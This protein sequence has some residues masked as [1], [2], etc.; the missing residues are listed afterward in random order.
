VPKT[1]TEVLD[2]IDYKAVLGDQITAEAIAGLNAEEAMAIREMA[3]ANISIAEAPD[4]PVDLDGDGAD[5]PPP[6]VTAPTANDPPAPAEPPAP[7]APAE[8]PP[9]IDR[10][11]V[12][13]RIAELDGQ[14]DAL[15]D[16]YDNGE[17]SREELRTKQ[18][19][20][21]Q[22]RVAAQL[23]L[24]RADEAAQAYQQQTV[25][26]YW[27][28]VEQIK[29]ANPTFWAPVHVTGFNERVLAIQRSPEAK[30][31]TVD[32]VFTAAMNTYR[33]TFA[34]AGVELPAPVT[35]GQARPAPGATA[36]AA[37]PK[38]PQPTLAF[39]PQSDTG[40][41]VDGTFAALDRLL[42]SDNPYIAEAAI[43]KLSPEALEAWLASQ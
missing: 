21:D 11:A 15:L 19:E 38:A 23:E 40:A 17:I 14:K 2:G 25:A 41:A 27:S 34:A 1:A 10:T 16:Q 26:A 36:P 35:P 6:D 5:P 8:P 43:E 3:E 20:I 32:Q 13:T 12:Q 37:A 30:S 28:R 33:Q 42:E 9:P 29:E 7:A 39:V 4:G 22:A 31:M 18:A 24:T